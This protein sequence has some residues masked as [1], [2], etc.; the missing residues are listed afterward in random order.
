MYYDHTKI[1]A[2]FQWFM[3]N[4]FEALLDIYILIYL[5]NA[6]ILSESTEVYTQHVQEV[7]R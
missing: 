1:P 2:S 3:S 4:T 6:L 5:D 7:L